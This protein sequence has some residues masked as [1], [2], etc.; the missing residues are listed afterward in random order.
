MDK[1]SP[2]NP[3]LH[4]WLGTQSFAPKPFD[5]SFDPKQMME[6]LSAGFGPMKAL[7]VQQME[8][9]TLASR[10]AQAYLGIPQRLSRCR[11]HADILNE[12][13]RFWQ[14]A[15]SQYQDATS[16]IAA[17]WGDL[18]S[19]VTQ[20]AGAGPAPGAVVFPKKSAPRAAAE[21]SGKPVDLVRAT[22]ANARAS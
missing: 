20:S 22:P 19:T 7:T 12:Q 5:T 2:N 16:R 1:P 21:A 11:T 17:A 15:M 4:D 6:G 8:L 3:H 18:F 14:T 13:M 9:M 10:R